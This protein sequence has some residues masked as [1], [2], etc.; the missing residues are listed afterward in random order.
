MLLTG[1]STT[2]FDNSSLL[3]GTVVQPA[4]LVCEGLGI[5]PLAQHA[6]GVEEARQLEERCEVD[7]RRS[8]RVAPEERRSQLPEPERARGSSRSERR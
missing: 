5:S 1:Q 4:K 7:E 3:L 6:G 2:L 8:L